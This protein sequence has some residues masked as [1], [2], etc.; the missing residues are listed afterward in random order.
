MGATNDMDRRFAEHNS[1]QT[2]STRSRCPWLLVHKEEFA[3]K[4]TGYGKRKVDQILEI[5]PIYSRI[6]QFFGKAPW[7]AGIAV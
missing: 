1:G 3:Q 7:L 5:A 2:T 4:A 6:D